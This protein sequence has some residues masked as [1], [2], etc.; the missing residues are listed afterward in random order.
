[1]RFA[2]NGRL[3]FVSATRPVTPAEAGASG[4]DS[5]NINAISMP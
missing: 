5:L 1:M 3:S 2:H 4:F